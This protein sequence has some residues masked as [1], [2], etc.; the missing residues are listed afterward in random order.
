MT[1][2]LYPSYSLTPCL[3]PRFSLTSGLYPSYS[4]TP[5]LNLCYHLTSV[6]ESMLHPLISVPVLRVLLLYHLR[7][8]PVPK[9]PSDL[10]TCTHAIPSD[11]CTRTCTHVIPSDLS[12][13]TLTI[14]SDPL[15]FAGRATLP[16][17]SRG[18]WAT[19]CC[20]PS[21]SPTSR[22]PA[23]ASG[24]ARQSSHT[25]SSNRT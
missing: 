15:I 12:L 7:S 4:L 5:G 6:P 11:L 10:C 22:R 24:A 17:I 19:P 20:R 23:P 9:L 21:L 8:V 16:R 13:C 14:P 1:C 3:Y 2:G 25:A 18:G